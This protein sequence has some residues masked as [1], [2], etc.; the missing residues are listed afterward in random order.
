M[1]RILVINSKGGC[2]KTT[3][4]T[5]LASWYACSGLP[6]ALIDYDAQGSS[7]RW[8]SL[9]SKKR[10]PVH[11]IHANHASRSNMTSSWSLRVPPDTQRVIM[12][13]PAGVSGHY[14]LDYLRN[15]DV[16]I[17]PVLPS[18]IDIHA[19]ARFI[20]D[21]L[22][23][24]K[25]RSSGI[26]VGVVANR[27]NRNTMIYHKLERFL[28]TLKL[29]FVTSLRDTQHYV[30]AVGSGLGVHEL[31]DRRAKQDLMH[32]QPLFRWLERDRVN[33][34]VQNQQVSDI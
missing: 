27:V 29:P 7:M 16:V 30:R 25:V 20:E 19:A 14:L 10:P 31:W 21:L 17:V 13:A 32:W 5:N 33:L 1:R 26:Q 15:V 11:C 9:R 24:G 8:A 18:H 6:T 28:N 23:I 22:L 4:A 2:G 12:D 34:Q 3:I